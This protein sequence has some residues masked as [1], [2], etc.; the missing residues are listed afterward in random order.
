[1]IEMKITITKLKN[2][3]NELTNRQATVERST[4]KLDI[5]IE[6]F[7][8]EEQREQIPGGKNRIEYPRAVGQ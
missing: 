5:S 7:K 2:A 6:T 1:M 8:T 3:F 4:S